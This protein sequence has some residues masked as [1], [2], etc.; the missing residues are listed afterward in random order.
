MKNG[1]P[2]TGARYRDLR[3][4]VAVEEAHCYYCLLPFPPG[5]RFPDPAYRTLEHLVPIG[6]GGSALDRSNV[7]AAHWK[8]NQLRMA[9]F[10]LT[11]GRLVPIGSR[12]LA[13]RRCIPRPWINHVPDTVIVPLFEAAWR[14][15]QDRAA[16]I[17]A[18]LRQLEL[19]RPKGFRSGIQPSMICTRCFGPA[20]AH[21][22]MDTASQRAA[23][24]RAAGR[25]W[26][27]IAMTLGYASPGAAYNA[28]ARYQRSS[29]AA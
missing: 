3:R 1:D 23:E 25:Q 10:R 13:S 29:N 22:C 15:E 27:D 28:A 16:H 9:A 19:T 20:S 17:V 18:A 24:M 7:R 12:Q 6:L 14:Q 11:E 21:C 8:C 26:K 4:Q 5:L 2:R